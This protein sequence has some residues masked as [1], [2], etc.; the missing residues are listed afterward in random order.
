MCRPSKEVL[1]RGTRSERTLFPISPH[2]EPA[3]HQLPPCWSEPVHLGPGYP[4]L[5]P[6]PSNCLSSQPPCPVPGASPACTG[7]TSLSPPPN[8]QSYRSCTQPLTFAIAANPT[9]ECLARLGRPRVFSG[10]EKRKIAFT[11][12]KK[13]DVFM[14]STIFLS[15]LLTCGS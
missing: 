4:A 8:L 3:G 14:P 7:Q 10:T 12:L 11:K 6:G 1:V 9:S 2:P 15:N 13:R 5:G